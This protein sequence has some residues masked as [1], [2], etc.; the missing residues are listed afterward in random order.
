VLITLWGHTECWRGRPPLG[1][2][3]GFYARSSPPGEC[4]VRDS[5]RSLSAQLLGSVPW[6]GILCC[7]DLSLVCVLIPGCVISHVLAIAV[8]FV[9]FWRMVKV[10]VEGEGFDEREFWF[11]ACDRCG[12]V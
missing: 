5:Q 12:R 9:A 6:S 7:A 8:D 2:A 10:L 11:C 1:A 4:I 3:E